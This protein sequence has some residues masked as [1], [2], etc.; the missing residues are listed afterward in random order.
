MGTKNTLPAKKD[1]ARG[2]LL[3]GTVFVHLDPRGEDVMVP[4]W[5]KGQAQLVLQLGLDMPIPIP[6]LRVDDEGVFGTLSFN[7]APFTCSVPWEVVFA[8]VGEDGRGMVWPESMPA[9][10]RAEVEREAGL[11]PAAVPEPTETPPHGTEPPPHGEAPA[12][13][14]DVVDLTSRRDGPPV[15][16]VLRP[17]GQGGPSREGAGLERR[18]GRRALPPYLRVVK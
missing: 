11:A 13:D 8:L 2:L 16:P 7:R 18:R 9:E 6:D 12:D 3:R 10:I 4:P 5:F 1:V 14:A 17:A 15:R